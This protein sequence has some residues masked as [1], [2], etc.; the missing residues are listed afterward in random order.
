MS[1]AQVTNFVHVA[2]SNMHYFQP[3]PA[4]VGLAS[5]CWCSMATA[6]AIFILC[7]AL[8]FGVLSNI[9]ARLTRVP[10]TVL[11]L[12]SFPALLLLCKAQS[13]SQTCLGLLLQ[14]F[15]LALGVGFESYIGSWQYVAPGMAIWQ[16]SLTAWLM[17]GSQS[18]SQAVSTIPSTQTFLLQGLCTSGLS[19]MYMRWPPQSPLYVTAQRQRGLTPASCLLQDLDPN[20]LAALFLPPVLFA[21]SLALAPGALL[22]AAPHIFLLGI[23]G[24]G[25]GTALTGVV[26]H[27]LLPYR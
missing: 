15:G 12:V 25:V 13:A 20:F 27:Y 18:P 9:L 17:L 10:A 11:L 16:V 19:D 6:D 8:F 4:A 1:P 26:C 14:L 23:V 24:V 22:M 3:A 21:G 5:P 7:I 2:H